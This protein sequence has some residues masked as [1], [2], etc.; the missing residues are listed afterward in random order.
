M[1]LSGLVFLERRPDV[2][3]TAL[4]PLEGKPARLLGNAFL[5]YLDPPERLAR[6]LEVMA[7]LAETVPLVRL[8]VA[9]GDAPATLGPIVR[10]WVA[11]LQ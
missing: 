6:Q 3:E 1:P 5:P 4:H 11:S 8:E 9:R 10:E 7:A 2:G